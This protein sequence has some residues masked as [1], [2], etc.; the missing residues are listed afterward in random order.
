[1]SR[2]ERSEK[3]GLRKKIQGKEF[4]LGLLLVCLLAQAFPGTAYAASNDITLMVEQVFTQPEGSA[5][6]A[7]FTY[8]LTAKQPGNPM[9]DGSTGDLYAFDVKGTDTAMI[10]P[11]TYHT[12]GTYSYELQQTV[13]SVQTGY[14]YDMQVYTVT[15]YVTNASGG[16]QADV[17]IENGN[18]LKVSGMKFENQYAPLPSD[19]SIMVDPPVRKTVSGSPSEN[20]TFTF[21]LEAEDKSSPMVA[22]SKDGVKLMTI[23]GAG[24]KDFG[25]W[26]YTKAGTYKYFISE[27]NNG[28]RGY[29]YDKAIY[30]ITDQVTDVNG[31]LSVQRT[32]TNT[33]NKM[34]D[35]YDFVNRYTSAK[36]AG[37]PG[38]D[39]VN[40]FRG[41]KTGD[42]T[43]VRPYQIMI[44]IG[45]FGVLAYVVYLVWNRKKR[46][47]KADC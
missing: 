19:P 7:G 6:E 20:G 40:I 22:G 3:I 8:T 1:M 34:V 12:T 9:P 39:I 15:V 13:T 33:D 23:V 16:L 14:T 21:K 45:G 26:S 30:T 32:V 10:D 47:M 44:L 2:R 31:Q 28:E 4:L 42:T 41:V 5:A 27:V 46:D 11:I 29:T 43:M 18:R 36:G 24:E 35:G 25:T 38:S 17:I 37:S